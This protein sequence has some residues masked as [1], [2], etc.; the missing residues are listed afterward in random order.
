MLLLLVLA[1]IRLPPIPP[2]PPASWPAT[3]DAEPFARAL[4]AQ[5]PPGHLAA[6]MHDD[7]Q[8]MPRVLRNVGTALMTKDDRLERYVAAVAQATPADDLARLAAIIIIDPIRYDEDLP[9]RARMNAIIPRTLSMLP[10]AERRRLLD[11][12]TPLRDADFEAIVPDK[13]RV[14]F[15]ASLQMPD[16]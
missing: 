8:L 1:A 6:A 11:A 2:L 13:R 3:A 5:V 16:D 10:A 12:D 4:M 14:A 15:N 9:F 7:P